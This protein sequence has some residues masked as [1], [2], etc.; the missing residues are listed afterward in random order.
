MNTAYETKT[1]EALSIVEQVKGLQ[2]T[3]QEDKESSIDQEQELTAAFQ[4]LMQQKTAQLNSLVQQ[5]D[6][7]QAILNQ[8]SQELEENRNAEATAKATLLDEQ[9]YL[10]TI[11]AQEADT[12]AM[13]NQRMKDRAEEKTAVNMALKVLTQ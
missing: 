2:A 3:F 8:V 12:T 13:Y 11:K 9:A 4:S 10:S 5:R 1:G 7:Q 6:T